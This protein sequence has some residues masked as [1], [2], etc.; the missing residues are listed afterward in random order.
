MVRTLGVEEEMLLVDVRNGRPQSVSGQMLVRAPH[1]PPEVA[2]VSVDGALER[3]FKQQQIE[4]HTAPAADLDTLR[5]EV[6]RWRGAA[7]AAAREAGSNVA[8]L[9]TSPFPVRPA[10][11]DSTRYAWM[12][13]RYQLT[14]RE[15]LVCGCHVH[16]SVEGDEEGVGVLDRIRVWLPTLLALSANSPF[17]NGVDSGFASYRS[18]VLARWPS[19]GPPDVFGSAQAYHGLVRRMVLSSVIL[20]EGMVYFDAR[21]AA[22]YPTVEIRSA[23]VCFTAEEA[24][25][26][27]ALCRGL[28]ETAAREWQSGAAAPDVPTPA[29]PSGD[30]AG[31][32]RGSAR[33]T[34][35]TGARGCPDPHG[36][37]STPWWTTWGRPCRTTATSPSS[38]RV[39]PGCVTRAT[40]PS[41]SGPRWRGPAASSTSWPSRCG[42]RH[43][44]ARADRLVSRRQPDPQGAAQRSAP[45][46]C[47]S[48]TRAV[49]LE[50]K[51]DSVEL[52]RSGPGATMKLQAKDCAAGGVFQ[53]EPERGDGGVTRIVHTLAPGAFYFDNPNFRARLGQF[54]GSGCTSTAGPAGQFC[55][56]SARASTSPTTVRPDSSHATAPR[57]RRG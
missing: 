23:D 15:Q 20:D 13:D 21:L 56:R 37:S 44:R 2:G 32:A 48:L 12:E 49:S 34:W 29:A 40:A 3:E 43:R 41:G 42:R 55:V 8:A 30:V 57:W 50:I 25:V 17:W 19:W 45:W 7:V 33:A 39:W 5:K 18:Q 1:Q 31:R 47:P 10:A 28:V 16:V 36:P 46:R 27:A 53:M 51:D 22:R 14:A 4:A 11:A 9:A 24:V 35:S 26:L 6:L 38:T 52:A 54:L